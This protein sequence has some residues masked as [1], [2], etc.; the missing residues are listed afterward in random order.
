MEHPETSHLFR[1]FEDV[2]MPENCEIG[3]SEMFEKDS[4]PGRH[5]DSLYI[6]SCQ[7]EKCVP[8]LKRVI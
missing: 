5:L 6:A 7:S 4:T 8:K 2:K 3:Q 1:L